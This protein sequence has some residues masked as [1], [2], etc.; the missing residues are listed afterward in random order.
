SE[1]GNILTRTAGSYGILH[2]D[3]SEP[4]LESFAV[5]E[6]TPAAAYDGEE[7]L[8][9]ISY[10][11]K[12]GT[13]YRFY[14][15]NSCESGMSQ[16]VLAV[17]LP[18]Y[19][20]EPVTGEQEERR[21]GFQMTD[22]YLDKKLIGNGEL[23]GYSDLTGEY[24]DKNDPEV[25]ADPEG[26]GWQPVYDDGVTAIF[27]IRVYDRL[28]VD[29]ETEEPLCY[30]I[31][32][33]ELKNLL[34]ERK[35]GKGVEIPY[36]IWYQEGDDECCIKYPGKVEIVFD[37][38]EGNVIKDEKSHEDRRGIVE[39]R[40]EVNRYGD[41]STYLRNYQQDNVKNPFNEFTDPDGRTVTYYGNQLMAKSSFID[42]VSGTDTKV[43]SK[44]KKDALDWAAF[45]VK[46][47]LPKV[48][49]ESQYYNRQQLNQKN[50]GTYNYRDFAPSNGTGG[51][52]N[53]G[54]AVTTSVDGDTEWNVV[55]YAREYLSVFG[56]TNDSISRMENFRFEMTPG[57]NTGNVWDDKV[58]ASERNRGFHTMD[59]IVRAE[60]FNQAVI[61]R[62]TIVDEEN[63]RKLVLERVGY[64]QPLP[65]PSGDRNP[66]EKLKP[67]TEDKALPET[68]NANAQFTVKLYDRSDNLMEDFGLLGLEDHD[69]S[70]DMVA[71]LAKGLYKTYEGD[72]V[73]PRTMLIA[74][75]GMP[76][77]S[78]VLV[79]GSDFLP[80]RNPDYSAGAANWDVSREVVTDQTEGKAETIVFV[81]IS[82]TEIK[83]VQE[84]T[85]ANITKNQGSFDAYLYGHTYEQWKAA[86]EML[87]RK[88]DGAQD[89][90]G[91][92]FEEVASMDHRRNDL[93][94]TYIRTPQMYFDTTISAVFRDHLVGSEAGAGDWRFT[95]ET[96]GNYQNRDSYRW[97]YYPS[98]MDNNWLTVGYKSLASYTVDF[99]QLGISSAG[100]AKYKS[101]YGLYENGTVSQDY[102]AA[103]NVEMVVTLPAE[104]FDAYFIKLRPKLRPFVNSVTVYPVKGEPYAVTTWRDNAANANMTSGDLLSGE[105]MDEWW[106]INLLA[107]PD[108]TNP[109]GD[110]TLWENAQMPE[111][112]NARDLVGSASEA[113]RYYKTPAQVMET[114]GI[115]KVVLNM[116]VNAQAAGGT[117]GNLWEVINADEGSWYE[118]AYNP[119]I[120]QEPYNRVY[121][122]PNQN[123]RH[124]LEIA[125]RVIRTEN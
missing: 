19:D 116:S 86:Y 30:T 97:A 23:T 101:G 102:N 37:T 113:H 45:D 123:T 64:T 99:R 93:D 34:E 107:D 16:P 5:K 9:P 117:A 105:S 58:A 12:D 60:L 109:D 42:Y 124:S 90:A 51:Y 83:N 46:E 49:A 77:I 6:N 2:I 54:S 74:R 20:D 79:E 70:Y 75:A 41:V 85:E 25:P 28:A 115:Q 36:S 111:K 4:T 62:I 73:I 87:P 67:S 53:D 24:H 81:G 96:T 8:L 103:A 47:P 31:R 80:M 119:E 76:T 38:F 40:G 114:G 78:Q 15:G 69:T 118:E 125:G 48:S 52:R 18:L 98:Y 112:Y 13:A 65:Q 108:R 120:Q 14:L 32:D 121:Q 59:I 3:P 100:T 39:L 82:D 84:I 106:R 57:L 89:T 61:D 27:E 44:D 66:Y 104:A 68:V 110:G 11:Y 91:N 92:N 7:E 94:E 95:D 56:L 55:P 88:A 22:I 29:A 63:A 17:E 10:E 50:L 26:A 1:Y 33:E 35:N 21:R 122:I 72:L 71:S 43:E